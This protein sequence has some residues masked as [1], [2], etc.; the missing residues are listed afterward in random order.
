[1][2]C[3]QIS[4]VMFVKDLTIT[5]RRRGRVLCNNVLWNIVPK[6]LSFWILDSISN[7]IE[8]IES[9]LQL[10]ITLTRC[11]CIIT[12]SEIASTWAWQYYEVIKGLTDYYDCLHLLLSSTSSLHEIR[13]PW[14]LVSYNNPKHSF[15]PPAPNITTVLADNTNIHSHGE[16][17]SSQY[18]IW[19][20]THN[21]M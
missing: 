21:L 17:T 13:A 4:W 9:V 16:V 2:Y 5:I 8:C 12:E 10:V 14:L 6:Y 15:R 1:M 11:C 3:K 18:N 7:P 20:M 19:H